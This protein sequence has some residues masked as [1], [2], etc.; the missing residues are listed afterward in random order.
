MT[1]KW[2]FL[3]TVAESFNITGRGIVILPGLP[4]DE[5]NM[6]VV[7]FKDRI[8]LRRPDGGMTETYIVDIPHVSGAKE[9]RGFA[10]LLPVNTS[11]QEAPPGTEVWLFQASE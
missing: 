9:K 7:R 2:I 10:I 5:A 6:P 1:D 4:R 11:T 8:Q 3:S